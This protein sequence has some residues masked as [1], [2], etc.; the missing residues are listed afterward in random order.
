M[1]RAAK[2]YVKYIDATSRL[3][4]KVVMYLIFVMMGILLYDTISRTVFGKPNI[5][6]VELTQFI[7]AAY[8]LLGGGFTLL[9]GGHVRMD[10]FYSRWSKKGKVIADIITFIPLFIYMIILLWGGIQ[11]IQYAI[12]FKQVTYSAWGPQVTPI[13][14]FMVAGLALMFLQI[15]SELIKDIADLKGE[16]LRAEEQS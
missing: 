11:G 5:W 10:L 2:T 4:G 15:I 6:A 1:I 14:F 13:K 16:N 12:E 8:Y 7:M 9:I 3:V